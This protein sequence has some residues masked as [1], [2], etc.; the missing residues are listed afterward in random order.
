MLHLFCFYAFI[1]FISFCRISRNAAASP[2]S[3]CTWWNCRDMGGWCVA[4][5]G[6]ICSIV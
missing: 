5:G 4:N 2:P 6:G 3:I 1:C